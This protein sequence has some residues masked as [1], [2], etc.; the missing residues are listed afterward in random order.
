M[1]NCSA[2]QKLSNISKTVRGVI[3]TIGVPFWQPPTNL[4]NIFIV[5]FTGFFLP[6]HIISSYVHPIGCNIFRN[7]H[8]HFLAKKFYNINCSFLNLLTR[9]LKYSEFKYTVQK[10]KSH[11]S[12]LIDKPK[13]FNDT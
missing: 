5:S 10:L 4:H 7:T 3:C 13:R 2:K 6:G 1:Y 11:W 8:T 12:T 9:R